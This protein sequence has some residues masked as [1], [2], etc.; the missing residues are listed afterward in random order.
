MVRYA[1]STLGLPG[2]PLDAVL[3]LA[4]ETGCAG[5]ELRCAEDEPIRPDM[6]PAERQAAVHA[7]RRA[8]I[9][10]MG[11]ASYVRIGQS[12]DDAPA[13]NDLIRHIVLATDLGIPTVRVFPGGEEAAACRRLRATADIAAANGVKVLVETH[14]SHRNADAVARLLELVDSPA[15]GA[16]WDVLHTHLG[17]DAPRDAAR[18]LSPH[19]G[20][21]QIKDVADTTS[22]TPVRLGAGVLPLRESVDALLDTGYDGWLVWE[23]EARWFP[24][25]E[26]LP[27]VLAAG[28]DWQRDSFRH[29]FHA[30]PG[31]HKA[32][33]PADVTLD[34]K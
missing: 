7:F 3:D 27:A 20:Y 19:L 18:L 11:L 32:I 14:D 4:A 24:A 21:V 28:L 26:P 12:G 15:I 17:G 23:Y 2:A 25:A 8:E 9:E 5:V 33:T 29:R 6:S 31:P 30:A 16:I 13:I 10:P 1:F 34:T 22:L